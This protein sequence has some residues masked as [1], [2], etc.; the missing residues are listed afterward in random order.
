M[1]WIKLINHKHEE[2]ICPECGSKL[3]PIKYGVI[4]A[5][6]LGFRKGKYYASDKINT[7]TNRPTDYCTMCNKEIYMGLCGIDITENDL[8]LSRY[9]R[10]IIIWTI[11]YLEE[12]HEKT[13]EEIENDAYEE[14]S[15]NHKEMTTYLNKLIEIKFLKKNQDKIKL[16]IGYAQFK[17]SIKENYNYTTRIFENNNELYEYSKTCSKFKEYENIYEYIE[18]I[19]I[20][21]VTSSW[22]YTYEEATKKIKGDGWELQES[23]KFKSCADDVAMEIG[24][25][26]G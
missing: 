1:D 21:L 19:K 2:C 15:L 22:H 11:E 20:S 26:G 24:Y 3:I 13:I 5:N 9:A 25:V 16:W 17:N 14:F 18:D 6:D 12:N 23:Y 4:M 10:E 8:K 7:L